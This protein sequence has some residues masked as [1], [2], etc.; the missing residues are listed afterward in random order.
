MSPLMPF[1]LARVLFPSIA[2]DLD[3]LKAVCEQFTAAVRGGGP[4][5]IPS[6]WPWAMRLGVETLSGDP[7]GPLT[8][9]EE[10]VLALDLH[11]LYPV[12]AS[13]L[14]DRVFPALCATTV[15]RLRV[16]TGRGTG[17]LLRTVVGRVEAFDWPARMGYGAPTTFV[18]LHVSQADG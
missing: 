18:E 6:Q 7:V 9:P 14:V 2:A 13:R 3:R 10:L 5:G 16:V 4:T 17:A 15:R 1:L 8:L 11:D 12:E